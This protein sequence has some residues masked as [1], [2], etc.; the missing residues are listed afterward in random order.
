MNASKSRTY[1]PRRLAGRYAD[2]RGRGSGY[3]YHAVQESLSWD[4]ALCGAI[5]GGKLSNGWAEELGPQVT[6]R[7]CRRLLEK[8]GA[9]AR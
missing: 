1:V 8:I 3:L 9:K 4:R 2:G 5:P 6:C 7:R